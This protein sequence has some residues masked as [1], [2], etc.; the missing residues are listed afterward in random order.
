MV[1]DCG[2][3]KETQLMLALCRDRE[4]KGV[5]NYI[6]ITVEFKFLIKD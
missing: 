4:V 2:L 3:K 5:D 1:R 6:N